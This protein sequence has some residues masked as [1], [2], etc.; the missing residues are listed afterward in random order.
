MRLPLPRMTS[1]HTVLDMTILTVFVALAGSCGSTVDGPIDS[2]ME[3]SPSNMKVTVQVVTTTNIV[4]D[5]ANN[6]GGYQVEVFSLVPVGGDPHSFQP[7]AGDVA[8]IADA[9]L[10]L[11]VGLG[12]EAFWL[13]ELVRNASVDESQ[14]VVLGDLI[15]PIE[16]VVTRNHEQK[17]LGQS[18]FDPHFWFDP[19]RVKLA[20]T[21]IATRLSVI[22]P[23][24]GDIYQANASQYGEQLD[25][26][27][28]WIQAEI[29]VIPS[30][31]RLIVTSHDS[32]SYFAQLYGLKVIGTVLPTGMTEVEPS[33]EDLAQLIGQVQE[34]RVRAV[35]GETTAR[36]RL[37]NAVTNET[38]TQLIRLYSGSLGREGGGAGT[39]IG[40]MR[41]NVERIV[42]ALK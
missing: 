39:Y 31:R 7:G 22:D 13:E 10:I 20:I 26:L 29:A 9:D 32:L 14:V 15:D 4:A 21:D 30:E 42:E 28:A 24:G 1:S 34:H 40:M 33:A 23:D 16:F 2:S 27:H 11:S 8:K 41:A 19:M 18:T 6:V 35:F 25:Q 5:W 12:L 38:G 36:E 3:T 17:G 37:A